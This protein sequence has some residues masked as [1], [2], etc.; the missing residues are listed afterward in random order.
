MAGMQQF[1]QGTTVNLSMLIDMV[2]QK[3]YHEL[4]LLSEL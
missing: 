2:L 3:T 1:S 4:T